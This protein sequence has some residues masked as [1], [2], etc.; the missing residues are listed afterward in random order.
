MG[1]AY[2]RHNCTGNRRGCSAGAGAGGLAGPYCNAR[3][4]GTGYA[5]WCPVGASTHAAAGEPGCRGRRPL[6]GTLATVA[7]GGTGPWRS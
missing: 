5:T 7:D 3:T 4:A 1:A 6:R 2:H